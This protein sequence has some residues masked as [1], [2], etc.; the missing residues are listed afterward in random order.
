MVGIVL[1]EKHFIIH[2]YP[3]GSSGCAMS[4]CQETSYEDSSHTRG[5]YGRCLEIVFCVFQRMPRC[6]DIEGMLPSKMFVSFEA[7]DNKGS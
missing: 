4:P 1:C 7:P 2:T 3:V 5:M 6:R